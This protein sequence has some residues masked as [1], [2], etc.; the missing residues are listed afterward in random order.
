MTKREYIS[1]AERDRQGFLGEPL[2]S[3]PCA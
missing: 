1:I 2:A 3:P